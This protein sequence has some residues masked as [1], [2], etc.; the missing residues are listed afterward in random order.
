MTQV[1]QTDSSVI[2]ACSSRRWN[3]CRSVRN[4]ELPSHGA[5]VRVERQPFR[6]AGVCVCNDELTSCNS[7]DAL[8]LAGTIRNHASETIIGQC[9]LSEVFV[10]RETGRRYEYK[11]RDDTELASDLWS[12]WDNLGVSRHIQLII[13]PSIVTIIAINHLIRPIDG[14][15]NVPVAPLM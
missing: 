8:L 11:L 4:A 7:T 9:I 12:V 6:S 5:D 10:E 15:I 2:R 1:I 14:E 13:P 3:I